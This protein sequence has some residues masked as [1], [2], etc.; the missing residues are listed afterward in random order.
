MKSQLCTM[1]RTGLKVQWV[2]VGG[3]VAVVQS[4]NHFKPN[5]LW[6]GY[7]KFGTYITYICGQVMQH[8][9]YMNKIVLVYQFHMIQVWFQRGSEGVQSYQ[10]SLHFKFFP[11]SVEGWGGGH[12]KSIFSQIQKSPNYPRSIKLWTFS[13]NYGIFYFE[14]SPYQKF[15]LKKKIIIDFF[16]NLGHFLILRLP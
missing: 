7:A 5:F 9:L 2:V 3:L 15:F 11:I 10:N 8:G 12:R 1:P 13:T 4:H 14:P 16:Y 6:L